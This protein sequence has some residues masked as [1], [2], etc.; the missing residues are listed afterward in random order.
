MASDYAMSQPA[1]VP[2]RHEIWYTD[3]T[4]GFYVLRIAASVWPGASGAD[5]RRSRWPSAGPRGCSRRCR[6]GVP[7]R[8]C[9][10]RPRARRSTP[11]RCTG[12]PRRRRVLHPLLVKR[13][14]NRREAFTWKGKSRD[15]YY[16]AVFSARSGRAADAR[17]VPL[18]RG[19]RHVLRPAALRRH[20]ALPAA[21]RRAR[22]PP[23]V[24]RDDTSRA[25]DLVPHAPAASA[26]TVTVTRAGKLVKRFAIAKSG[27]KT[28]HLRVPTGSASSGSTT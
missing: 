1:F 26:V 23:R 8:G 20:R 9:G 6:R 22:R 10:S 17:R 25:A 28:K 5:G 2:A 18:L 16:V 3:G 12:S 21:D 24:G 27:L 15:G 14:A 19:A 4:S 13:F 11:C 7:G